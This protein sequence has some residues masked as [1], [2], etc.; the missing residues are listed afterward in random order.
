MEIRTGG[1]TMSQAVR[2][3]RQIVASGTPQGPRRG[4]KAPSVTASSCSSYAMNLRPHEFG[5][6]LAN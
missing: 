3:G 4:A 1:D 6:R 2:L 5:G